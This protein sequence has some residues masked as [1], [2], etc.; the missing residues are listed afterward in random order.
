MRT[1]S[2]W[3]SSNLLQWDGSPFS[4]IRSP[5]NETII[6]LKANAEPVVK[7]TKIDYHNSSKTIHLKKNPSKTL[8]NL[9]GTVIILVYLNTL[10]C[11]FSYRKRNNTWSTLRHYNIV[12]SNCKNSTV[13]ND[14]YCMD[15]PN[16][17][18]I[19]H[20]LIGLCT[21]RWAILLSQQQ[22]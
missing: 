19:L 1:Y 10:F 9:L 21:L 22:L 14:P 20:L 4:I 11:T 18:W 6:S 8:L 2:L 7:F 17:L 13:S 3:S 5:P 12:H 15:S 16:Q